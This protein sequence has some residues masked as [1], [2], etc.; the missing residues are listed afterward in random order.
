[1][2][3]FVYRLSDLKQIQ[4]CMSGSKVTAYPFI[5]K[6][7]NNSYANRELRCLGYT[8]Q[9]IFFSEAR[10]NVHIYVVFRFVQYFEQFVRWKNTNPKS[11]WNYK[12]HSDLMLFL[13]YYKNHGLVCLI[14]NITNLKHVA[15]EVSSAFRCTPKRLSAALNLI[16]YEGFQNILIKAYEV[17]SCPDTQ[18]WPCCAGKTALNCNDFKGK[19]S[20]RGDFYSVVLQCG[21]IMLCVTTKTHINL[22]LC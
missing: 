21:M 7:W 1:M 4:G 9:F 22:F 14:F 18:F 16:A 3:G 17:T 19:P 2:W 20:Q 5:T 13:I 15:I 6:F 12:F 10:F 11:G 8:L